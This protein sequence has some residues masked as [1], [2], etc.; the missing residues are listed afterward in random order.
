M[1]MEKINKKNKDHAF[2]FLSVSLL[3]VLLV[4]LPSIFRPWLPFD[5]RIIYNEGIAPIPQTLDEVF[6]II[7]VFGINSNIESM[8]TFFSNNLTIRSDPLS[9]SINIIISFFL[10]KNAVLYHIL[11]LFIHLVNTAL[12]WFILYKTSLILC[13]EVN[14]K[15]RYL[16]VSLS[17]VLWSLH[18]ANTEAVLL[19][20][21]WIVIFTFTFCFAFIAYEISCMKKKQSK[22]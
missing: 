19:T 2:T 15:Y 6:E 13:S 5:E 14:N 9:N 18:S 17:T 22:M 12:V 16:I 1:P 4:Y 21:N 20:T 10:R 7:R 3:V 8:N 11:Q